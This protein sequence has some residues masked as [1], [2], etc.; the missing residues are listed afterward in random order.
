MSI[1]RVAIAF[2]VII[3]TYCLKFPVAKLLNI[4]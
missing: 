2:S 1:S 4:F 3:E